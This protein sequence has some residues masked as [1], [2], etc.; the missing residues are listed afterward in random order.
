MEQKEISCCF[1]G[2]RIIFTEEKNKLAEQL[3]HHVTRLISQGITHFYTGGALGFDTMAARTVLALKRQNKAV[4]LHLILPCKEQDKS[5]S[6]SDHFA[7]QKI[8]W[9]SDS[10]EYV[11]EHYFRG[12]M[13]ERNRRLVNYTSYC[14][15]YLNKSTGGT[16]YTVDYAKKNGV[17]V[18]NLAEHQP[19][20]SFFDY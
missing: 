6:A 15:C 18:I 7:Y 13:H 19:Q 8:L 2:H 5:W 16:A 11:S 3:F 20:I 14:I 1:T 10:V 4:R 17:T 9:E 12:C